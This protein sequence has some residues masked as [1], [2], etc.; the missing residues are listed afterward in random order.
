MVDQADLTPRMRMILIDWL[1][2]V[3]MKYKLAPQ[4]LHLQINLID[5]YL[6]KH[7][8]NRKKLQLVGV[9]AAFIASKVEEKSAPE[10]AEWVYVTDK[11]YTKDELLCLECTMLGALE[12]NLC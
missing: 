9:T 6:S 10:V 11:A 12:F 1:I 8:V 3:H 7:Q 4:G 5:R 2:E